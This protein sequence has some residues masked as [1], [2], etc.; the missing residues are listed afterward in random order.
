MGKKA[1]ILIRIVMVI[2]LVSLVWIPTVYGRDLSITANRPYSINDIRSQEIGKDRYDIQRGA[3]Q[4]IFKIYEV[5]TN[6][7]AN[8]FPD[9]IYCLR[10]GLGFGSGSFVEGNVRNYTS[11]GDM[12]TNRAT[13]MDRFQTVTGV[14]ISDA[15][16]NSILWIIDQMYLPRHPNTTERAEMRGRLLKAADI[17]PSI[18]TITE[19][20]IEVVQQMAI[21]QFSNA[22]QT[23]LNSMV[24][25]ASENLANLLRIN[26]ESAG[27]VGLNGPRAIDLVKLYN[28][29][30]NGAKANAGVAVVAPNLQF[31]ITNPEIIEKVIPPGLS[32][33]VVGPFNI[34]NSGGTDYELNST[35]GFKR[36]TGQTGTITIDNLG[37]TAFITDSTGADQSRDKNIADMVNKGDFYIAILAIANPNLSEINLRV[38]YSYWETKKAEYLDAGN[39]EQPVVIVEKEKINKTITTDSTSIDGKF[40]LEIKKVDEDGN[41]ILNDYATFTVRRLVP[42]PVTINTYHTTRK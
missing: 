31:G 33:Y 16:Y 29:L 25:E 8:A 28:Y 9:A 18:T 41:L 12:R 6:A 14:P 35:I 27:T 24:L 36:S 19:D 11:Y 39:G 5:G 32:Y 38:D 15:N 4:S 21:W 23:G 13:I 2:M 26:G 42:L 20:D 1:N 34:T 10:A 30:V 3:L 17:E 37:G 40:N 7:G 22:D